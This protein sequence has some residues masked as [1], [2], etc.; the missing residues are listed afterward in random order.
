MSPTQVL[1][2]ILFATGVALLLLLIQLLDARKRAAS[3]GTHDDSGID[4]ANY[5]RCDSLLT[6]GES[7]FFPTLQT[8]C[9]GRS[10]IFSQVQLCKLIS[11]RRGISRW[12]TYQNKIDRKSVDFVLCN[13]NSFAIEL[14]IELDDK[15]HTTEKRKSRDTFLDDALKSANI[16]ILHIAAASTYSPVAL[17]RLIRDTLHS[18]QSNR[19]AT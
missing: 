6:R 3:S 8:A 18:T 2:L 4:F 14:I 7:A 13:P 12:Q 16:P 17:E 19:A 10:L 11:P 1:A 15:T 5:Q 9:A